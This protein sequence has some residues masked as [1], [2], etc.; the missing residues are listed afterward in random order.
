MH[1]EE[2]IQVVQRAAGPQCRDKDM[3]S[4]DIW[5]PQH[6]PVCW[7]A[8]TKKRER[9]GWGWGG[10]EKQNRSVHLPLRLWRVAAALILLLA[11]A[12]LKRC[13]AEKAA[14]EAA[15]RR[16]RSFRRVKLF[17]FQTTVECQGHSE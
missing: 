13:A 1:Q 7:F 11:V 6:R 15:L 2:P 8:A 12:T 10:G 4:S 14:G 3:T 9:G 5:I 17:S 16:R